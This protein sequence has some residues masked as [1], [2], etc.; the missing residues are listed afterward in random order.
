MQAEDGE[1]ES[2][3]ATV[4]FD[5]SKFAP[6]LDAVDFN[7]FY[8]NAKSTK[9]DANY[10]VDIEEP[11]IAPPPPASE[12]WTYQLLA[13]SEPM[14][15]LCK[16]A[17]DQFRGRFEDFQQRVSEYHQFEWLILVDNSGSMSLNRNQLSETLVFVM[18]TLR[19]LECRF[20]IGRFGNKGNPRLL[21]D[22][23]TPFSHELGEQILECFDF[24]EGTVS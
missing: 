1:A 8:K 14:T 11:W 10:F 17:L 24:S 7:E 13:E 6:N 19:K 3:M 2:I 16:M 5:M 20:A 15:R 4:D 23:H 12:K 18:E 22:L 9:R 21:K